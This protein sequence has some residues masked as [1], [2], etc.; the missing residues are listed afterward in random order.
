MKA[1]A[2]IDRRDVRHLA[3]LRDRL[4]ARFIA[5]VVLNSGPTAPA[6]RRPT[7]CRPDQR[8]VESGNR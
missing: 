3:K 7:G 2:D 1:G 4:G 5:G 8:G 6:A